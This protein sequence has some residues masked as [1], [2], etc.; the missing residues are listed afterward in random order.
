V[1]PWAIAEFATESTPAPHATAVAVPPA[2]AR[3]LASL[4]PAGVL[5]LQRAVGNRGVGRLLQRVTYTPG[6]KHDHTPSGKWA[7]V[8]QAP[9]SG[10]WEN[11]VCANSEPQTVV[12]VA[13]WAKFGDKPI[14]KQHLEWYLTKGKGKDFVEDANI[15]K[16][17]ESDRGV[18]AMIE[19]RLPSPWP[20]SG[21]SAFDFKVEQTDY[22]DQDLRFAFGAIDRLDVE[23]DWSAKTITG[24]FQDRYEWHPVYAGLYTKYPDDDARS[25]NCVHAA[26]VELQSTG[27]ADYWMKGE[28]TVPLS[29]LSAGATAPK[30]S[31]GWW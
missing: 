21:K 23:V 31:S 29:V 7:D 2:Q 1:G 22:V 27:A 15:K 20:T 14:A 17:L 9:N 3:P 11:R 30:K 8:K 28:A 5:S 25:T 19:A 16:M 24:W 10:F 18:Q 4:S 13:L 6:S 12:D 26:L